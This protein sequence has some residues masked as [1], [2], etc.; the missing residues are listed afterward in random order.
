MFGTLAATAALAFAPSQGGTLNLTNARTTYGE[1][2][3]VRTDSRFLPDDFYFLAFD[4][5]GLSVTPEGKVSYGMM[6]EVTKKNGQPVFKQDRISERDEFLVLGGNRMPGRAWVGLKPDQEPGEYVCRVT[7][8]DRATKA[9]KVLERQFEVIK[10]DFG[11]I[12]VRT[13]FD[14][15]DE[16]GN[17][18]ETPAPQTGVVGQILYLHGTVSGFSRGANKKPNTSI[19]LRFL[20][21]ARRPTL[22]KAQTVSVPAEIPE[23]DDRAFISFVIPYNREGTYTAELKATDATTGKTAT[24]SFPIRVLAP[25]K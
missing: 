20:D 16:K 24:V 10:K 5:D 17:P 22:V 11:L 7:V 2:G 3:P 8:S 4:M 21:E 9:T 25:P 23:G 1:M 18:V 12:H 14:T 15:T 19:E 13:T 6:V